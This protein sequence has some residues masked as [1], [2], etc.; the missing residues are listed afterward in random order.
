MVKKFC[1]ISAGSNK[2]G[3]ILLLQSLLADRNY[4][5]KR[6]GNLQSYRVA[7]TLRAFQEKDVQADKCELAG[8]NIRKRA[9]LDG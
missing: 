5:D 4:R 7:K 3:K 2:Y 9:T 1:K 6:N 8:G